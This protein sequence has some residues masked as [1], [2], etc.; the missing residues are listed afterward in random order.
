MTDLSSLSLSAFSQVYPQ[1]VVLRQ[2]KSN[3]FLTNTESK[4]PE[5]PIYF[6]GMTEPLECQMPFPHTSRSLNIYGKHRTII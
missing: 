1:E 5:L 4:L 2:I 3:Q 6:T